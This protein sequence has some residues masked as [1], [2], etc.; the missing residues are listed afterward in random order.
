MVAI[1]GTNYQ[2]VLLAC[3]GPVAQLD[4]PAAFKLHVTGRTVAGSGFSEQVPRRNQIKPAC[5]GLG[6]GEFSKAEAA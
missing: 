6:D 1:G 4:A 3:P 5:N 2:R